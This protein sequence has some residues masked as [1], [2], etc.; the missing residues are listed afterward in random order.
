MSLMMMW[1]CEKVTLWTENKQSPWLILSWE[2]VPTLF[3]DLSIPSSSPILQES[4]SGILNV[5]YNDVN[6]HGLN[7]CFVN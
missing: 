5:F 6:I 4:V 2:D 7:F 3:Y 1:S